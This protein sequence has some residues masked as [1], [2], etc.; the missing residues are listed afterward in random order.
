MAW[1]AEQEWD[2]VQYKQQCDYYKRQ[3]GYLVWSLEKIINYKSANQ[4]HEELGL[5]VEI[6]EKI[7]DNLRRIKRGMDI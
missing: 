6:L 7:I 2:I 4:L 1:R 5:D 3:N